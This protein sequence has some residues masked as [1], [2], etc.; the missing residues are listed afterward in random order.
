MLLDQSIRPEDATYNQCMIVNADNYNGA[1]CAT[2]YLID[3]KHKQI[4][5]ITGG[6]VKFSSKDRI[7]GYK[8]A[9]EDAG[10]EVN[11]NL[12]VNSEFVENAGYEAAKKLFNGNMSFRLF[13][14]VMIK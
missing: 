3:K 9:L 8:K 1:Y 7:R 6:T 12:I 13:L 14:P 11:K 2:K 5:H 4:A 10:I